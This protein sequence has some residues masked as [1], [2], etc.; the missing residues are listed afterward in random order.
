MKVPRIIEA[1]LCS[2][3]AT[4]SPLRGE[5]DERVT[6]TVFWHAGDLADLLLR[7]AKDGDGAAISVAIPNFDL[8][9]LG[10]RSGVGEQLVV[11]PDEDQPHR[12]V[13]SQRVEERSSA[14]IHDLREAWSSTPGAS[15]RSVAGRKK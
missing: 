6:L 11:L 7:I 9:L 1:M 3:L 2:V 12:L 8:A 10:K 4:V 13:L 14:I 5:A 15:P